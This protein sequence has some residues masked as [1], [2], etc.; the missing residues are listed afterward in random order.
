MG[1]HFTHIDS[2]GS[3]H[4]VDV[5]E[6]KVTRRRAKARCTVR[7]K[8]STIDSILSGTMKK[9]DVLASAKCAGVLAAKRVDELI[10]LCHQIRIDH[11]DLEFSPDAEKGELTI[12][13]EVRAT[14]RTGAEMEA[15]QAVAQAALTIYDMC[16][17]V[18]RGMKITDIE[19]VEK[20]GGKSGTW[21]KT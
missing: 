20:S 6:K 5:G 13:S 4:M 3:V 2:S 16:K 9:G 17:A 12:F 7:M 14:A 11:V 15:L 18:D 1:E 21:K 8:P 10:P 19:L